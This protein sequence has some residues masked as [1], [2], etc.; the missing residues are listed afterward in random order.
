[1]VLWE[2]F[3]NVIVESMYLGVPVI[4]T[5][6]PSGPREILDNGNLGYLVPSGDSESLAKKIIEF[7][8]SPEEF[9]EKS[10]KAQ[11]QSLNF[12]PSKIAQDYIR[13]LF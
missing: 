8:N 9:I 12:L 13:E 11:K 6:C 1:M 2:G 4:S 10:L 5:D 7:L 3:G